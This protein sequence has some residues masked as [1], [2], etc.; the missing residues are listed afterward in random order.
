[1][2]RYIWPLA[3]VVLSNVFYQ[4]C[5]K[6]VPDAINPFASLT[7]TYLVGAAASL[8]MF[9]V[10]SRGS[11][12]FAEYGKI[13]WASFVLGLSIIGLEVGFIYMYKA[14]WTISTAQ[15]VQS[16]VLAIILIGVGYILYKEQITWNKIIGIAVCL[17]GLGIL[18]WK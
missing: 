5:T 18:N 3:L 16:A 1:M 15:V 9:F 4:I 14:G 17:A 11:S 13:N 12:L 6:S 8:L 2:F 10:T 7:V